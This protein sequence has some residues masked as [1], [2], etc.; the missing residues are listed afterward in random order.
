[1][2]G[3]SLLTVASSCLVL[4]E[5]HPQCRRIIAAAYLGCYR[6]ISSHILVVPLAHLL[7]HTETGVTIVLFCR[8]ANA[9]ACSGLIARRIDVQWRRTISHTVRGLTAI[10]CS[11]LPSNQ[12][13]P[14]MLKCGQTPRSLALQV[15]LA[16]AC[17]LGSVWIGLGYNS[18]EF[19]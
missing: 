19:N 10:D 6:T 9:F 18:Q 4:I 8:N 5:V 7:R 17:E 2:V 11:I 16:I 15:L 3:C 13:A 1:M 14:N 12:A